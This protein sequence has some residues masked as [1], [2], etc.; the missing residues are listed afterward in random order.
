M[1]SIFLADRDEVGRTYQSRQEADV[2]IEKAFADETNPKSR[3]SRCDTLVSVILGQPALGQ[4]WDRGVI[5]AASSLFA[6]ACGR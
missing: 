4:P 5:A 2:V 1:P 6:V 3:T